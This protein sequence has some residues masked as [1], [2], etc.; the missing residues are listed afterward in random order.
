MYI[1][2]RWQLMLYHQ[3]Y[4]NKHGEESVDYIYIYLATNIVIRKS[5]DQSND[6]NSCLPIDCKLVVVR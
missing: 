5:S 6:V 2:E 3:V 1:E 4:V